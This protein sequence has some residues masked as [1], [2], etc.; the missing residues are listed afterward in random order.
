MPAASDVKRRLRK[1]RRYRRDSPRYKNGC[2][3]TVDFLIR[4]F[5]RGQLLDLEIIS[6][7]RRE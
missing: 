4:R 7:K 2:I 3:F 1:A 6:R 5:G